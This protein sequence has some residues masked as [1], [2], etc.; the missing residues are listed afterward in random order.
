MGKWL[1]IG[2]SEAAPITKMP[3]SAWVMTQKSCI[4]GAGYPICSQLCWR[5]SLPSNLHCFY[6]SEERPA[7]LVATV[8]RKPY[9]FFPWLSKSVSLPWLRNT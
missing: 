6:N 8:L 1:L 2:D 5:E 4:P 9:A 7:E 3:I